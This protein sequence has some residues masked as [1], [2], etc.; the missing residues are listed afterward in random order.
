MSG[1]VDA[2]T[3]T[4]NAAAAAAAATQMRRTMMHLLQQWSE[5]FRLHK[6]HVRLHVATAANSRLQPNVY[7]ES[8][9]GSC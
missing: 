1:G 7:T 4:T 9:R 5:P 3:M 8:N 6:V 2:M